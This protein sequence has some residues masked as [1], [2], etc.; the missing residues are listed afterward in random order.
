[1]VPKTPITNANIRKLE[2]NEA[3]QESKIQNNKV[4]T[5]VVA[6]S[7]LPLSPISKISIR[8]PKQPHHNPIP[9]GK[10]GIINIVSGSGNESTPIEHIVTIWKMHR[11]VIVKPS[12]TNTNSFIESKKT[13]GFSHSIAFSKNLS[14]VMLF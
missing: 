14:G 10:A 4:A 6:N 13:E 12:I 5:C 2:T 9:K 7:E 3:E 1:M 11:F 8:L